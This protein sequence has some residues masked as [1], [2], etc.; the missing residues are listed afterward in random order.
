LDVVEYLYSNFPAIDV[1]TPAGAF[2]ESPANA[3]TSVQAPEGAL[4][5]P[6]DMGVSTASD[7]YK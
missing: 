5:N 1:A 4:R 3:P 2:F 7:A 6:F